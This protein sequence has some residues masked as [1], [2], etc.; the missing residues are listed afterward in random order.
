MTVPHP[1]CGTTKRALAYIYGGRWAGDAAPAAANGLSKITGSESVWTQP[2]V[3]NNSKY[4]NYNDAPTASLWTGI[5]V[6][7]GNSEVQAGCDSISIS[8]AVYK[9]WTEDLPQGLVWEGPSVRP[10][11]QM[12]VSVQY[13]AGGE[14]EY[15]FENLTTGTAQSIVHNAPNVNFGAANFILERADGLYLPNFGTISQDD[16]FFTSNGTTYDGLVS[17]KN[18]VFRMTSNC[19]SSGT[20]LS[21]PGPVDD[22]VNGFTQNTYASSPYCNTGE[23]S[24]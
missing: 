3:G 5:G 14:A 2:K 7:N 20:M 10:G 8:T 17:G 18:D 24:G 4:T 11:Q 15:Y 23:L 1:V 6:Y 13:S 21:N 22:S 19:E 9:C 16:N 12:F